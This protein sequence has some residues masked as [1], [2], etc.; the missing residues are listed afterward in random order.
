MR[1]VLELPPSDYCKTRVSF[2]SRYG[3]NLDPSAN[4]FITIPNVVKDLLIVIAY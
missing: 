3:I 4:L 2:E 1:H